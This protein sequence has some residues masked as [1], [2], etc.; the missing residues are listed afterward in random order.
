MM[1]MIF[2]NQGRSALVKYSIFLLIKDMGLDDSWAWIGTILILL[3]LQ[4]LKIGKERVTYLFSY[5]MRDNDVGGGV[6]GY[7]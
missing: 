3:N 4:E 2:E 1:V 6:G 5:A 7:H